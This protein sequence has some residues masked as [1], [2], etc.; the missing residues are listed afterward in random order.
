MKKKLEDP[1]LKDEIIEEVNA[2]LILNYPEITKYKSKRKR[3]I[4]VNNQ[5]LKVKMDELEKEYNEI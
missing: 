3:D 2:Y 5:N 4:E 1:K